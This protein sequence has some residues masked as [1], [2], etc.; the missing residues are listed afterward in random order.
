MLNRVQQ[1]GGNRLYVPRGQ[2]RFEG[3]NQIMDHIPYGSDT[4]L[5]VK[6]VSDLESFHWQEPD[7]GRWYIFEPNKITDM[8]PPHFDLMCKKHSDVEFDIVHGEEGVGFEHVGEVE[9]DG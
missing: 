9:I 5:G 3:E 4:R 7:S 6:M 8:H 2:F 1:S